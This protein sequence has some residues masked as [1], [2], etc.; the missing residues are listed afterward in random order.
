MYKN[1]SLLGTPVVPPCPLHFGVLLVKAEYSE[2][3]YRYYEGVTGGPSLCSPRGKGLLKDANGRDLTQF[4][5]WYL[6]AMV[7]GEV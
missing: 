1:T 2:Q 6:Q 7:F 3:G 5:R 4:E